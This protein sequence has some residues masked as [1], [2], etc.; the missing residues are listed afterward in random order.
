MKPL[1]LS[2]LLT[3]TAFFLAAA[4]I[5]HGLVDSPLPVGA[6]LTLDES[7]NIQQGVFLADAVLQ[8]GPALLVP[9][10]SE[11]VFGDER[12]LP[13][14]PPAARLILGLAHQAFAWLIPGVPASQWHVPAARLGSCLMF[15]ATICLLFEFSRRRYDLATAVLA[16]VLLMLMPRVVGHARLA[17]QETTTTFVWLAAFIPLLAWWTRVRPP[18]TWQCVISGGLWG[19]LLLTKV[20]GILLPP[21]VV[22]WALFQYRLSAIRPLAIWGLTGALVFGGG[23]PWLW[24]DPLENVFRYLGRATD[25]LELHVWYLHRRYPDK[26]VPWHFPF[27]MTAVT[28]PLT[29]LLGTALRCVQRRF[30]RMEV[31]LLAATLW[32]LLVFA[33][34]GVPVYD[35]TRLF[36]VIMPGF[37]LLAARGLVLFW[38]S[39]LQHRWQKAGRLIVICICAAATAA[40]VPEVSSPNALNHYNLLVGGP[41]GA[42]AMGLESDYWAS[43]VTSEFWEQVPENSTVYVAP[44]SHQ[45]QLY[46]AE[47]L[48]PHIHARNI[49]LLPYEYNP[50]KQRGLILLLHRLADLPRHLRTVPPGAEVVAQS[51]WRGVVLYRLID[52]TNGTW[53]PTANW[54]ADEQ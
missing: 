2:I 1:F 8:H 28:V 44:I 30:D 20:Q 29:V 32:P 39:N 26:Q 40:V 31:L 10:V 37:A 43:G 17:V 4:R 53:Q 27:V 14:H 33:F 15:A 51:T 38:N 18:S 24:L 12:Y 25:R 46:A 19:I 7:F 5:N 50:E 9:D 36:L 35:G 41:S 48:I 22:G 42:L 21:F 16:A 6:G 45:F 47:Q 54:P 34:P 49:R 23:W 11:E 13:D 3:T 52:T